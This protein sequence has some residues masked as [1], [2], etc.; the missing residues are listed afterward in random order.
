MSHRLLSCTDFAGVILL[1]RRLAED[2][3]EAGMLPEAEA[4]CLALKTALSDDASRM[5]S[6]PLQNSISLELA[7]I[8]RAQGRLDEARQLCE[9]VNSQYSV[10]ANPP[11]LSLPVPAKGLCNAG[12]A[13]GCLVSDALLSSISLK[14]AHIVRAQGRLDETWQ[15]YEQVKSRYSASVYALTR[16]KL[17]ATTT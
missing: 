5:S 17:V 4:T 8:V 16:V 3:K 10:S 15:L 7:H 9:Q 11:I 13:F 2:Q 6:D 1:T 12:D 14:L